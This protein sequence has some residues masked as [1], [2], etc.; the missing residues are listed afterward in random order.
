VTYLSDDEVALCVD[1]VE[2]TNERAWAL[3]KKQALSKKR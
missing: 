3:W 2:S 1:G